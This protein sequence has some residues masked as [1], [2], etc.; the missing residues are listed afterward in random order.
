[1]LTVLFLI[2][3]IPQVYCKMCSFQ[4][5]VY[6]NRYKRTNINEMSAESEAG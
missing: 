6:S 2:A 1:V 4:E 5:L 3:D